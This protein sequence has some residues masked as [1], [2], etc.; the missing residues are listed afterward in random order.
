MT[1]TPASAGSRPVARPTIDPVLSARVDVSVD[2]SP[3]APLSG[4][5]D[6]ERDLV[7]RHAWGVLLGGADAAFAHVALERQ[8]RGPD[9]TLNLTDDQ[10]RRVVEHGRRWLRILEDTYA[11]LSKHD[12]DVLARLGE[13]ALLTLCHVIERL[14]RRGAVGANAARVLITDMETWQR[15]WWANQTP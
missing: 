7:R 3:L 15:E 8:P 13:E 4:L 1:R 12:D 6:D 2:D 11:D 10:R 14:T 5:D 9:G